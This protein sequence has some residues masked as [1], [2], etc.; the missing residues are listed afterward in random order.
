M[1]G[2][3]VSKFFARPSYQDGFTASANRS[4]PDVVAN[5]DPAKGVVICQASAGGCPTGLFYGGTSVTAPTWAAF[6]AILNQ[7]QGHNLGSLNPQIYP[8]A[9]TAAFHGPASMGSDFAHVG[10]GSPN[11]NLVDL[12]LAGQTAGVPDAT[13]SSLV[14][15]AFGAVPIG[16]VL[17]DN[18]TADG[19]SSLY[20]VVWLRDANGNMVSGKTV[21]LAKSAGSSAVISPAS[22]VTSA[23]NGAV[24]FTVSNAVAENV[25][26]TATDTTDG[27]VL[28]PQSV[29]F[30]AP[31]ATAGGHH[32]E[33]HERGQ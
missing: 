18:P 32:R 23:S 7:A 3:G 29:T 19:S 10:L 12:A 20:V 22:G 2:F 17:G 27:V 21:T 15:Y 1:G 8:L 14:P 30:D 9:A 28:D 31:P 33:S 5:G 25:T 11:L 26:F 4:V 13:Q 6:A 24:V 16:G